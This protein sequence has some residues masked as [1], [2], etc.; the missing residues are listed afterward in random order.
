M[1]SIVNLVF[2]VVFLFLRDA[3]A[4]LEHIFNLLLLEY[5]PV[6]RHFEF[7][8]M[9]LLLV[10]PRRLERRIDNSLLARLHVVGPGRLHLLGMQAAHA[11]YFVGLT[12][13]ALFFRIH[14]THTAKKIVIAQVDALDHKVRVLICVFRNT[15]MGE[16]KNKN[17]CEPIHI[18]DLSEVFAKT[19]CFTYKIRPW[20]E[21]GSDMEYLS[22]LG[23][24]SGKVFVLA[25]A[26]GALLII[27]FTL[28]AKARQSKPLLSVENLNEK[29]ENMAASL[30]A[31][32]F[33]AKALKADQKD[34]K[35]K[36]KAEKA[37][38][39]P[40]KKRIFVLDF[41]G[42]IRATHLENLRE[43]VTSLLTIARPG[44]DEVAVRLESPGG[45][46]SPYGLAAAQL[47]RLRTAGIEL[48]ICVDK[49][50]ASGGYMMACTGNRITAAPFAAIGSIGVVAEIPNFHRLLKK[51]NVDFEQYTAGEFKRTV[52]YFGEITE[53]GKMKTVEQLEEIHHA[54]KNFVHNYRP[55]LNL[56]AVATGEYWLG[57]R[58]KELNLVDEIVSSDDYLFR[59]RDTA[60]IFKVEIQARKKWSEKLAE[61]IASLLGDSLERTL[62]RPRSSRYL[63]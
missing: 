28:L 15:V 51:H 40:D 38:P 57:E 14:L 61:N 32:V 26:I 24:F 17:N 11:F 9:L 39:N 29:F 3:A 8:H 31:S 43:E 53:K 46:V 10:I 22:E 1:A 45:M 20:S 23:V 59:Q 44:K 7:F 33:E 34:E 36:R 27:F 21:N 41:I 60:N 55:S 47:V 12:V 37:K 16:P 30:K 42:D 56:T 19:R 25:V 2:K 13:A 5:V 6:A 4:A 58:A 54:F 49:V 50:A 62:L 63:G 18:F 35:R 48:T 52:S